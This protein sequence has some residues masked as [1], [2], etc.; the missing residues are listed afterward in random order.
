MLNDTNYPGW[1]AYVDGRPTPIVAADY[2]FRGVVIPAGNSVVEFSY[3]PTSLRIGFAISLAAAIILG[4][5]VMRRSV[6]ALKK[7][8]ARR[9]VV[10][11]V[12]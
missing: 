8:A 2:L 12:D 10:C 4:V 6:T 11:K 5:L 9:F 3:E 7:A 1:R